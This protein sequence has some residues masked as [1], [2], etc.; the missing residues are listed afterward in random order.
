MKRQKTIV[1]LNCEW[2]IKKDNFFREFNVWPQQWYHGAGPKIN[3]C[4]YCQKT[5]EK[6]YPLQYVLYTNEC[7]DRIV[8]F[9]LNNFP[10]KNSLP[11][12]NNRLQSREFS[13]Y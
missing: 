12:L 4:K 8:S 11:N 6:N 13:F 5:L 9:L 2:E 10:Q 7:K 1:C 3:L